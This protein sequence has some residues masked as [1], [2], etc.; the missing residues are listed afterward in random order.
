[1]KHHYVYE[2]T[3]E[4][5]GTKYIG[6]R[7]CDTSIKDD[8]LYMG[9]GLLIN[10]AIEK[11]GIENFTKKI[12]VECKTAEDAFKKEEEI[13]F[14]LNA[15][16]SKKYY[17]LK[18]G[19]KG[20]WMPMFGDKNPM[21]R[22]EVRRKRAEGQTGEK[23]H[24]YGKKPSLETRKKMS[25]SHNGEK[26]HFYGKVHSIETRR[27]ISKANK[28]KLLGIPKSKE[29]REKMSKSNKKRKYIYVN[30]IVYSSITDA[31]KATKISR[32]TLRKRANDKNND[33]VKF[34]Q[35]EGQTT[36]EKVA[37]I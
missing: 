28:G 24:N 9:S 34:L 20:K 6:K 32:P 36:I 25:E 26:N 22:L 16:D 31:E 12:L 35:I 3:N 37:H 7:T 13:I 8:F 27:K 17:N 23:N 11:H 30:G 29:Q 18:A 14:E 5:N 4:I 1:M 19:G 33:D 10:R 21:K 15:V 2:I